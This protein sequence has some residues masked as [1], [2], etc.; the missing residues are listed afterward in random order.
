[1]G[2]GLAD[3]AAGAAARQQLHQLALMDAYGY[4]GI[5]LAKPLADD[6][7]YEFSDM[8]ELPSLTIDR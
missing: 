4:I 7:A 8:V 6:G 5:A 2:S 1:M 3:P